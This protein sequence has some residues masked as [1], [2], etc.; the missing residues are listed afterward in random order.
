MHCIARDDALQL[1][2][3]FGEN[4]WWAISLVESLFAGASGYFECS[5]YFGE[6]IGRIFEKA[7]E[8]VLSLRQQ[9]A[10]EK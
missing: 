4:L 10:D 6:N 3:R 5:P 7:V 8:R 2:K 9:Q 1:A